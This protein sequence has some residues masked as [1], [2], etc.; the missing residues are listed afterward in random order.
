MKKKKSV[1]AWADP[2]DPDCFC[3]EVPLGCAHPF[4]CKPVRVYPEATA[5][6]MERLVKEMYPSIWADKSGITG[7]QFEALKNWRKAWAKQMEKEAKHEG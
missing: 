4:S 2:E 1:K 7:K 3:T 5:R 6:L